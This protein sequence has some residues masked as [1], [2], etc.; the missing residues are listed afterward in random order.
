MVRKNVLLSCAFVSR[1]SEEIFT[2][3]LSETG[4]MHKTVPT[5]CAKD[6]NHC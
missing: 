6:W 1:K 2:V 3:T 5:E 4:C